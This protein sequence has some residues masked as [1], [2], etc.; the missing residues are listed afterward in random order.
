ME[1]ILGLNNRTKGT[2]LD[3]GEQFDRFLGVE[4]GENFAEF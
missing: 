3:A 2:Q 1:K 4:S